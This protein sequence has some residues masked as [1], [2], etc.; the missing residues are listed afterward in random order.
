MR[1]L[2]ILTLIDGN[3]AL[4]FLSSQLAKPSFLIWTTLNYRILLGH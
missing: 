4:F 1:P 3:N 2:N